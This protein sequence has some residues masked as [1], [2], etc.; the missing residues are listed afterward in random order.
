MSPLYTS[1]KVFMDMFYL[2]SPV[3]EDKNCKKIALKLHSFKEIINKDFYLD[4][5]LTFGPLKV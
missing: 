5:T 4:D 3:S 1:S 2:L